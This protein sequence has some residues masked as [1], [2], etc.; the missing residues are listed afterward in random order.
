MLG[1][2]QYFFYQKR[3]TGRIRTHYLIHGTLEIAAIIIW[4]VQ[5]WLWVIVFFPGTYTRLQS[6]Q[7]GAKD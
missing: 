6:F 2:F 4:V 3:I 1:S 7:M 5:V